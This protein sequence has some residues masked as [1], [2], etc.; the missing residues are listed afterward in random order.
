MRSPL[1]FGIAIM[2]AASACRSSTPADQ[3]NSKARG[4]TAAT[5]IAPKLLMAPATGTTSIVRLDCGTALV[6]HFDAFFSDR[7]GL[8]PNGPR[9]IT[10]SC[11]LI[12]HNGRRLLWDTGLSAALKGKQQDMGDLIAHVDRTIVEQLAQLG[13][14]PSDIQIVGISHMHDDH[15]GQVGDFAGAR[16]VI[17]TQDWE[18]T[19]GSKDPFTTWRNAPNRV[20]LAR[21]DLDIFGDGDVI[22]L[23]LP[24]HTPGHHALL[25]KLKSGPVLLTGDLYH[26]TMARAKRGVPPFN[27]SR[28]QTLQSMD[29]F[30]ALAKRLGAKVVIQHEPGDIDKLPIFPK[31]AE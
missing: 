6:K 8:Y 2:V 10:D 4:S 21:G 15:T 18:R 28:E 30:E 17:G 14:K 29:R 13:I 16:L 23:F 7:P 19:R 22:A 26:S 31:A 9:R 3:P 11:Y 24:G 20:T 27:T 12:T 25:V 5:S 1:L